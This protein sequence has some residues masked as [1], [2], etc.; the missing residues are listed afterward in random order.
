M[1]ENTNAQTARKQQP[2]PNPDLKKF[3]KMI[4]TWKVTGG[5]EGTN[6]FEWAEGG[7]FLIQRYDVVRDDHRIR[8]IEIIG[9]EKGITGAESEEIKSKAYS[10]TDGMAL[11]YVYEMTDAGELTIWMDKK[12]SDGFMKGA[13]SDDGDTI[14]IE[15]FYPGG[16]YTASA[17]RVK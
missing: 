14:N 4:G 3:E 13:F 15:W 2:T 10:F 17:T 6:S 7:F 5:L 11:D 9:H 12:G 8:G 16:G 1:S